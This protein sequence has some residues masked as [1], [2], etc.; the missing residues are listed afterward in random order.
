MM[1]AI[2]T[3]LTLRK[4]LDSGDRKRSRLPIYIDCSYFNVVVSRGA[5][6]SDD[7]AVLVSS[8]PLRNLY[9]I[10]FV[11]QEV[12]GDFTVLINADRLCPH[13]C[14]I[15]EGDVCSVEALGSA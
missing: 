8:I 13:H 6:S 2:H 14:D 12:V 11:A 1:A 9:L 3:S 4:C 7:Q 5:Q 15:S 10:P